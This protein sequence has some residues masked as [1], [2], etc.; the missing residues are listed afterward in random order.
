VFVEVGRKCLSAFWRRY[1]P[2]LVV[3]S[4]IQRYLM[5]HINRGLAE[6]NLFSEPTTQTLFLGIQANI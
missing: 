5:K 2:L 1:T 3:L 6:D 4:K